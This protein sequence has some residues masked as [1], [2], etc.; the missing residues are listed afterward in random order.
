M[1]YQKA[2]QA[3]KL[4]ALFDK[5]VAE[6]PIEQSFGYAIQLADIHAQKGNLPKAAEY[7]DK[8]L[9]AFGDK[10]PAGVQEPAWNGERAKLY[11]Y[12]AACAYQQKDYPKTIELYGQMSKLAPKS[13]T[14]YYY[15]GMSQ[16]QQKEPE[17]A[18]ESFAKAVVLG[19]DS[20]LAKRAQGYLEQ[21]YKARH[22]DTL[23]GVDEVYAKAKA[24]LG[25]S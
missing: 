16:W 23:D 12:V 1:V 3:D 4:I 9:K 22:N 10:V 8:V 21:L 11:S 6:K 5:L 19:K 18:I 2:N 24:A 13:E 15:I 20:A 25:I 17:A 7:A 14:P